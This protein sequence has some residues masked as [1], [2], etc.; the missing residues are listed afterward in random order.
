[1]SGQ[2]WQ[3]G[4]APQADS[5]VNIETGDGIPAFQFKVEG[6]V[7]EV[8]ATLYYS[9]HVIALRSYD[10]QIPNQR[11][12][13]RVP[14]RKFST[15]VKQMVVELDRD[16]AQ[17]PESNTV[18]VKVCPCKNDESK[19]NQKLC[20]QWIRSSQNYAPLDG[21]TIRR[22]GDSVTKIRV[23]LHL[24]QHPEHFKVLPELG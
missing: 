18:E 4:D 17:Y 19:I 6:R 24:E 5:N 3:Q 12:K 15:L 9:S 2:A 16:P 22:K 14:P 20:A 8:S 7:L 1:M 13:D 11:A 23:I 21:F 10:K